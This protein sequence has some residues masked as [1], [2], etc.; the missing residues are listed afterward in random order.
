MIARTG[1]SI[2]PIT[3]ELVISAP[4]QC[5]KWMI[6]GAAMPGNRYFVPPEKPATSCGKTG[7]QMRTWSCSTASRLRATGTDRLRRP[8]VASS[9]ACAGSVPSSTNVAG[10]SH[11]WLKI[12]RLPARPLTT[13]RPTSRLRCASSIGECVP[14]ATR[15]SSETTRGP[16]S[17]SRMSNMSGIGIV[18]VPSGM[19]TSTR[20]PSSGRRSSPWRAVRRTSSSL[21]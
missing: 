7:P 18:R 17:R 6:S 21:R 20:R 1:V 14:S 8:Q 13:G 19:I 9:T 16:S 4:S 3:T 10:S 15:K 11:R 5:V 2:V 12:R